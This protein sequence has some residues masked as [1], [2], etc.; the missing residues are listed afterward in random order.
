MIRAEQ[1]ALALLS[2]RTGGVTCVGRVDDEEKRRRRCSGASALRAVAAASPSAWVLM[3]AFV[4]VV[5]ALI[6]AIVVLVEH[7]ADG[8]LVRRDCCAGPR[9]C[10]TLRWIRCC[11]SAAQRARRGRADAWPRVYEQALEADE[12]ADRDPRQRAA[13]AVRDGL[14][15]AGGLCRPARWEPLL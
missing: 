13:R 7:G 14:R 10:T 11:S 2:G 8:P 1:A 12:A 5:V 3:Q 6:A 9:R 4:V 15:L